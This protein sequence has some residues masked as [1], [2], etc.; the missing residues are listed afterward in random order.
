MVLILGKP[1]TI[2]FPCNIY[3]ILQILQNIVSHIFKETATLAFQSAK[4][5]MESTIACEKDED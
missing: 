4:G 2:H 5:Q 3:T 1:Y